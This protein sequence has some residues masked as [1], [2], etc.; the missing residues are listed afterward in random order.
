MLYLWR[1]HGETDIVKDLEI[2][3]DLD[4]ICPNAPK[5]EER[6]K[7]PTNRA[8]VTLFRKG[9]EMQIQQTNFGIP[10]YYWG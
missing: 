5:L 8:S 2:L 4:T 9:S 1:T 3:K 10:E 6:L 7:L